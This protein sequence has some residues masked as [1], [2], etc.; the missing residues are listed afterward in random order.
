MTC[1][2]GTHPSPLGGLSVYAQKSHR[3]DKYSAKQ[4]IIA[5]ENGNVLTSQEDIK[6]RWASYAEKLYE[7]KNHEEFLARPDVGS[8]P[9]LLSEVQK[10]MSKMKAGKAPGYDDI[11]RELWKTIGEVGV[12]VMWRL[13]V[14]IW[15][16]GIGLRIF[17]SRFSS[18][19]QKRRP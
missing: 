19:C 5:D 1:S 15:K 7:H 8:T 11:P 18:L 13:C 17:R 12:A 3:R 2:G 16:T 6:E 10:A 14:S 4:T 9:P